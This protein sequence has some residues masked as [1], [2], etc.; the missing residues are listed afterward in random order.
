MFRKERRGKDQGKFSCA[1]RFVLIPMGPTLAEH[2]FAALLAPTRLT[3]QPLGSLP[4]LG[5]VRG[6]FLENLWLEPQLMKRVRIRRFGQRG[7]G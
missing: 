7:Q 6:Q 5:F 4:K 2:N 1:Y 3:G